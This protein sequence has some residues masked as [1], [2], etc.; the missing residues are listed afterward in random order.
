VTPQT[1]TPD[2]KVVLFDLDGTLVDT[3]ALILASFRHATREVLGE[4]LPDDVLLHNVGVP[5][6]VQMEEFA[7][8]HS[9]ELLTVYRAYN[10]RVHDEMIAEYAGTEQALAELR[11]R[12]LTLGVVTSKSSAPAR[13][14]LGVF[15]LEQYFDILLSSDD[16]EI[17]KPD[18]F[19]LLEA[20]RRLDIDPA[21]CVYVGDSPHD[22]TAALAAGMLA[23]A[24][25]WGPF[26][27]RVLE[28]GPAFAIPSIADLPGVLD[29][30]VSERFVCEPKDFQ[31]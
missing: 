19:P 21:H 1:Q 12:G 6:R 7:P 22:M 3:I 5:L 30:S 15:G 17:H 23:V 9:E 27:E 16:T 4:A 25:L 8:G 18:P 24:A 28:P 29:G 11:A 10:A 20:A 2:V 26:P 14:S 13:R 31:E